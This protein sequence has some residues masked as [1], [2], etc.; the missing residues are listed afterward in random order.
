M[1]QFELSP[2][3]M[4]KY[5]DLEPNWAS[6]IGKIT[7]YRTYSR[8]KEDGSKEMFWEVIKRCTE[9]CFNLILRHLKGDRIALARIFNTLNTSDQ[10]F[11]KDITEQYADE[12]IQCVANEM[13]TAM[14]EM[15]F[16]P[17]GRGLWMMGT[18]HATEVSGISLNN[19]AMVSTENLLRNPEDGLSPFGFLMDVSMLGAGCGFDTLGAGKFRIYEPDSTAYEVYTIPDSREGWVESVELLIES[20][21]IAGRV[22]IQFD[23]SLIRPE[24]A[25]I[26]GFGGKASGPKPLKELHERIRSFL[27]PHIGGDMSSRQIVDIMNSIGACV[28]AGNV[29]RSSLIAL[30]DASDEDFASLKDYDLDK[31]QYRKAI[32]G[33]S[34]NSIVV[35]PDIYESDTEYLKSKMGALID[36]TI[37]NGEPGYLFLDLCRQFGRLKAGNTERFFSDMSAIGT[38]PCGEMTLYDREL[39]NLVELFPSKW[40]QEDFKNPSKLLVLAYLYGKSVTLAKAHLPTVQK[41]IEQ[42]RRL[43]ISMSG[44]VLALEKW[45][46][47]QFFEMCD[48]AYLSLVSLDRLVS[49]SLGINES[50]KLTTVKPSGTVSLVAGVTPG[51]HYT[52]GKYYLKRMRIASNDPLLQWAIDSGF[53]VEKAITWVQD[54]EGRTVVAYMDETSIIEIPVKFDQDVVSRDE[55]SV[56]RQFF[57][58]EQM[59]KYWSD[60]QISATVNFHPYEVPMIKRYMTKALT[61]P[62]IKS[63]SFSKHFSN[64]YPQMPEEK[65]TEEQYNARMQNINMKPIEDYI[66]LKEAIGESGCT[67]DTCSL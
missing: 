22:E 42:N 37:T 4:Q 30:A 49:R 18:K 38:N 39:C 3:F 34:N 64:D 66:G 65:L 67:N 21:L 31:N 47:T 58:I 59:Q 19:C 23:Y 12:I 25:K 56:D 33:Y 15:K 57:I 60:N 24:G 27:N 6:A 45:G 36:Q 9:G 17:P 32:G 40:D 20:Y 41:N 54:E 28:V 46:D 26:S 51:I 11:R 61:T 55:V 1:R 52:T 62:T 29:R 44:I 63:V 5:Q 50:I 53:K 8:I 10:K 14:F 48:R 7:F 2:K 35:S 16:L 13:F 43:G